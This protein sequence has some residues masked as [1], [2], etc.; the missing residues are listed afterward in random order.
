MCVRTSIN[1]TD[2]VGGGG[3]VGGRASLPAIAKR[4]LMVMSSSSS[5]PTA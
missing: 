4:V 3:N 1:R 2:K 5:V